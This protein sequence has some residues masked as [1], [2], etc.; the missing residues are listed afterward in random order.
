MPTK[1]AFLVGI[2]S[3][4]NPSF[5]LR[6]CVNDVDSLAQV[7]IATRGFAPDDITILKDAQA[8]QAGIMNGVQ[9]LF[10]GV[11]EGDVLVFGYS[12]HGT[13][14][15][16]SDDQKVVEGLVPYETVS[17]ASLVSNRDINSIARQAIST[18]NLA[19]K[20]NFTAIYDCCHSGQMYRAL[21]QGKNGEFVFDDS[22][23]N[24]VLDISLLL[25]EAAERDIELNDE[26]QVFSACHH[27]ETAADMKA[28][29][30]LNL[31]RPRGAFSF[32]L[33]NLIKAN[34]NYSVNDLERQLLP[35]IAD[36][37]KPHIQVPVFAVQEAW[38]SRPILTV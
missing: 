22:L 3:Y 33:H 1:K 17:T 10:E 11:A 4:K 15:S 32:V 27:D 20:M 13:E 5:S 16:K 19:G 7:L 29:P 37:V 18:R 25:P 23:I 26:F 8:T 38:K 31:D 2:N 9:Q 35:A 36:L 28:N 24:R 12:G 34:P 6:G 21:A 14:F 30:A